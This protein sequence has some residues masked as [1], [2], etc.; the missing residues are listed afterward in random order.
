MLLWVL[1]T[2]GGLGILMLAAIMQTRR[3]GRPINRETSRWGVPINDP[4]SAIGAGWDLE[5]DGQRVAELTDPRHPI[6]EFWFS[7]RFTPLTSNPEVLN[8]LYAPDDWHS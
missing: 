5:L 8:R 4:D 3:K 7:Y 1:I 6:G 2:L